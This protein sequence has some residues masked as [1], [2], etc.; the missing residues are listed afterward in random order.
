MPPDPRKSL[1]EMRRAAEFLL[2][3]TTGRTLDEYHN[4]EILRSVVE[5][6]FE[7]IGEALNRLQ[8]T[9]LSLAAAISQHRQ[10]ISFRNILIHG[11]DVVDH[12]VVWDIVQKD[13]PILFQEVVKM[14][15]SFGKG[16]GP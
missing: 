12:H 14:L 16:K 6:K 2:H 1:E 4:D 15:E 13:L 8:K 5:R 3:F 9:D 11:Y 7:I 10:I